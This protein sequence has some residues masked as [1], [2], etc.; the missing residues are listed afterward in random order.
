MPPGH[1]ARTLRPRPTSRCSSWS[2]LWSRTSCASSRT[3][4]PRS[5]TTPSCSTSRTA[6]RA[7]SLV[8]DD[9]AARCRTCRGSRRAGPGWVRPGRRR[10]RRREGA[11]RTDDGL[12]ILVPAYWREHLRRA[13]DRGRPRDR[14]GDVTGLLRHRT[15][16]ERRDS[17]R[18]AYD[19]VI[20]GGGRQRA[21]PRAQP[22]DAPRH[23]QRRGARGQLHRERRQRPQHPGRPRQLQHARDRAA[24]QG[25]PRDLAH[26]VGGA[27]F[28]P[29]VL[30]A[31]ASST[32]VTPTTPSRSSATSRCSTA[33]TACRP[34][35]STPDEI[36][37]MNPLVDLTGGGEFPVLGASYHPPGLDRATRLGGVGVRLE[38]DAPRRAHPRADT[39]HRDRRRR[40]RRAAGFAPSAGRSRP[41]PS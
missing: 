19:V 21:V 14:G 2:R 30:D 41:A 23:H 16:L 13:R 35:C 17:S 5:T 28:Q 27:R 18:D 24:V 33:P 39:G 40:R 8:G 12:T 1:G 22:R 34:T 3:G 26:A 36:A 37:R 32:S 10:A 9:A 15:F 20:V 38:R 4:S 11:R 31:A 6:G 29:A 25:E 7:W